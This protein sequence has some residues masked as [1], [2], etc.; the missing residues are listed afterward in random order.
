[1]ANLAKA[2]GMKWATLDTKA[3]HPNADFVS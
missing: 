1:L 3:N 2:H